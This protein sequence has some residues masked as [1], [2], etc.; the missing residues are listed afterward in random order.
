MV[1]RPC[2][3]RV[4]IFFADRTAKVFGIA[5]TEVVD[6][7]SVFILKISRSGFG[8]AFRGIDPNISYLRISVV[9]YFIWRE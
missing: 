4:G 5:L 3:V 2:P 6:V 1:I 8:K 7:V 9:N